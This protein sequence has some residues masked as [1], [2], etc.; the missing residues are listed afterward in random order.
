MLELSL[1]TR[2]VSMGE[3]GGERGFGRLVALFYNNGF[4]CV[5]YY[6]FLFFLAYDVFFFDV[7]DVGVK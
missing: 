2:N 6:L 3:G 4:S 1:I 7:W 5:P